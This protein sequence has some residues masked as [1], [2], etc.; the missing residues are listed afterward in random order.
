M[1]ENRRFARG[2]HGEHRRE[3][4]PRPS[5]N[6]PTFYC[7][8]QINKLISKLQGIMRGGEKEKRRCRRGRFAIPMINRA[9]KDLLLP[10]QRKKRMSRVEGHL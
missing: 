8:R 2:R 3:T 5:W 6:S 9:V 1:F 7:G 4:V 10:K